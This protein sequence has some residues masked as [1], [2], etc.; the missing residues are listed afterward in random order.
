MNQTL[1]AE[2]SQI[3]ETHSKETKKIRDHFENDLQ[4]LNKKLIDSEQN[5]Q[6]MEAEFKEH[7]QVM[8]K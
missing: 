1:Q 7:L 3:H 6:K 4:I 2:L 8:N 5:C